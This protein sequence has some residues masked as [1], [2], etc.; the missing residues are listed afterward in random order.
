MKNLTKAVFGIFLVLGLFSACTETIDIELDQSFT[1]LVVDGQISTDT[2]AHLVRL[3]Q[4]A[5]YFSNTEPAAVSG[6]SV[7]V[8]DGSQAI[9]LLEYPERSGMY[10]TPANYYGIP[11]NDYLLSVS[12]PEAIGESINYEATNTM[13]QTAFQLD[14]IQLEFRNPPGFWMVK[15]FAMDP[16][17]TDFYRLDVLRNGL[18]LTDTAYRTAILDD[19]LI[20]GN[21]TNGITVMFLYEDEV[22]PGDTISLIMS[23]ISK[24]YY[25]F[26]LELRNESGFSNPLFGGPPANISSNL[27][28]GGLG[29]FAT[30]KTSSVSL[31]ADSSLWQR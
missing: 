21:N 9:T 27:R 8:D 2:M 11:G 20:N 30:R 1:R 19:R 28:E 6:A 24:D 13:P 26:L 10:Y 17:T 7:V 25:E 29:Y 18:I 22:M 5:N 23:A 14:S 16:P 31:V 15:L 3:S 12:L 4:S